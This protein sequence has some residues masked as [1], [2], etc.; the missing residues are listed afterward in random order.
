MA[1][2][3]LVRERA[4]T[5]VNGK[6]MGR[7]YAENSNIMIADSM[8]GEFNEL[9]ES[10]CSSTL[11]ACGVFGLCVEAIDCFTSDGEYFQSHIWPCFCPD[12]LVPLEGWHW[13]AFKQLLI[14]FRHHSKATMPPS[15]P[16]FSV[17][18]SDSYLDQERTARMDSILDGLRK[19]PSYRPKSFFI[20]KSIT[21]VEID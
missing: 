4:V 18:V 2:P 5:F 13:K 8:L 17:T 16:V 21:R 15:A 3:R 11:A 14:A 19:D 1:A 7:E 12:Y 9:N 6:S 10:R 20:G